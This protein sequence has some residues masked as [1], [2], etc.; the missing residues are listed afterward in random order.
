MIT[1]IIKCNSVQHPCVYT[2]KDCSVYV[3]DSAIGW[4]IHCYVSNWNKSVYEKLISILIDLLD[5]SPHNE[6]FAISNNDKLTKFAELFG[7]ISIDDILNSEG[8]KTGELL[9]CATQLQ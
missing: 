6:V 7:F 5:C 8:E 1:E 2:D 9:R 4:L 3:E